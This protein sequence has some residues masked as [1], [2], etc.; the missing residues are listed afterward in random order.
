MRETFHRILHKRYTVLMGLLWAMMLACGTSQRENKNVFRYNQ[1]EGIPTLDPAFAKNQAIIWAVHQIY[2]TLVEP[3]PIIGIKPSLA[4]DWTISSDRLTYTFHLRGDVFFHDH[5]VFAG[6]KGRRM[7]AHDIVYSFRR[8]MDPATASPGAWIFNDKVDP[9]KGFQA[10]ND[11]TFQLQLL[12]PFNP[13]L[14]ILSMQYCSIV[15][16][17]VVEKYGKDF[18]KHPCGTGPFQ[19]HFW[20]EGQALVLHRFPNYFE[21]D[22]VGARLPYLDAVQVSFVDS[23]GTEFLLFMQ[24]QLD[25][26]NDIESSFK[27]E[28]LSKSGEL[29]DEW[30]GKIVLDKSFYL[31]IEYFGIVVD[32]ENPMVRNSPLKDVKIRQ[33]INYAID[34]EKMMM[35][36]RNNIGK[37]ATSGCLPMGLPSFDSVTVK[38]YHY[39]PQKAQQLLTEAAYPNGKG[40]PGIKLV[41]IPLYADMASFVANQLEEVGIKVQVEIIQKSSLIEQASKV[42]VPFFRASW[43]ADY[44]DAESFLAVFYSKNPAPPNYT[45]FSNPQFDALYEKALQETNDSLRYEEYKAM[46]RIVIANAPVVPLFYDE[47]IHFLQPNVKG[48]VNN[49]LNILE[50]RTVKLLPK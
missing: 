11:T 1:P 41:S 24:K 23:R 44:P 13:I 4:K 36:L 31:N 17:E 14:G 38:G 39:H 49:S 3:D 10:I 28:V 33:A 35:Y 47:V 9:Q 20:E 8:V 19:F 48:M 22:S 29:K 30:K 7:T 34:R 43:I 27:D 37:P 16:H 26:M 15:P 50:L 2:N 32:P 12:K 42:Q 45:R 40:M 25:F 5:E 46:D 21:R 18:R 6:G